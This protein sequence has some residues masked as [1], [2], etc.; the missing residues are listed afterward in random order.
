MKDYEKDDE[1]FFER[2]DEWDCKNH[3]ILTWLH[4]TIHPRIKSQFGQVSTT[5]EVWDFLLMRYF[6]KGRVLGYKQ[7]PGQSVHDFISQILPIPLSEP[8]LKCNK[9]VDN[10]AKLKEDMQVYQLY[11]LLTDDFESVCSSLLHRETSP[12]LDAIISKILSK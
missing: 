9:D 5:K 11:M 2:F 8:S 1:F 10:Y 3:Q 6:T 4:S 7:Q 12:S